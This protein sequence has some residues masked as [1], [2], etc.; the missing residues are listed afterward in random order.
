MTSLAI[1]ILLGNL[2]I[3]IIVPF[4]N[5]IVPLLATTFVLTNM[6]Y[7]LQ[8]KLSISLRKLSK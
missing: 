6:A 4:K 2:I 1:E 5:I 7:I 3:Q 8:C